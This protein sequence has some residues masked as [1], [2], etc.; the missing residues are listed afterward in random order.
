M[1]LQ[2]EQ[3]PELVQCEALL[4]IVLVIDTSVTM[5]LRLM[6]GEDAIR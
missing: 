2:G 4:N 6:E 5:R 1:G 3:S